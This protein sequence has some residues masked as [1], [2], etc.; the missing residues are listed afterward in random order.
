MVGLVAGVAVSA[1]CNATGAPPASVVRD[2]A[3][4]RILENVAPQWTPETAWRLS[5]EPITSIGGMEGDPSQELYRVRSATRL[6]NGNIV[7]ANAGTNELRF[8]RPDG[9]YLRSAGGEG[10]GPGEFRSVSLVSRLAGDSL[11]AFDGLQDRISYFDKNGEFARSLPLRTSDEVP[12]MQVIGVFD[13]GA[14]LVKAPTITTGPSPTGVSQSPDRLFR[15]AADGSALD[16]VGWGA[17]RE[18]FTYRIGRGSM[19]APPHFGRSTQYAVYDSLFYI[20]TNDVYEIRTYSISGVLR[21]VVRKHHENL[22]VTGDDIEAIGKR[23]EERL[24]RASSNTPPFARKMF[25]ELPFPETMPAFGR[26]GSFERTF[27]VDT[28]ANVW[29]LEYNRPADDRVRWTVFDSGGVLRGTLRVPDGL[30]ILDIGHDYVLGLWR[31]EDEV[32]HVMM[33][34]LVKP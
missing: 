27:H 18:T 10:G 3:G 25:E 20:A 9:S 17:G 33:Y 29:V 30:D 15:Y 8:F 22:P 32:E 23:S 12:F 14:L 16:S 1:A 24:N 11:V 5:Q 26:S 21:S 7:I 28:E 2:S 13:G 4:V 19:G 6:T 34:G 31:D